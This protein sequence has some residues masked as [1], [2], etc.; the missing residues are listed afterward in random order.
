MLRFCLVYPYEAVSTL[1]HPG[2]YIDRTG[3]YFH[4]G[5]SRLSHGVRA[6]ADGIHLMFGMESDCH[7]FPHL[8]ARF[9]FTAFGKT[10][11]ERPG[12]WEDGIQYR[13]SV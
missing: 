5:M 4:L 3:G 11:T 12:K 7:Y 9:V 13:R 1:R 6:L 8:V 2:G 10:T